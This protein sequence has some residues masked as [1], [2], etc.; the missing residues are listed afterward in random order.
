[1]SGSRHGHGGPG[2]CVRAAA[3]DNEV[4]GELGQS[5]GTAE[6]S[7]LKMG[8]ADVS[9][10]WAGRVVRREAGGAQHEVCSVPTPAKTFALY[11]VS[12]PLMTGDEVWSR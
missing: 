7:L 2:A 8:L 5:C 4:G 11:A 1:M 12:M 6:V 3:G 9:A 10:P